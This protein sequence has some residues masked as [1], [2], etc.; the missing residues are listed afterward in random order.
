MNGSSGIIAKL[1]TIA[2]TP[3][4]V[5]TIKFGQFEG[6]FYSFKSEDLMAELLT[7]IDSKITQKKITRWMPSAFRGIS[8]NKQK[9]SKKASPFKF[10]TVEE[11]V[12]VLKKSY[13]LL[14][15]Q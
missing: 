5:A 13:T 7:K 14:D 4:N 8:A 11:Q 12:N 1:S 10:S 6:G 15:L 3:D 9:K 2:F